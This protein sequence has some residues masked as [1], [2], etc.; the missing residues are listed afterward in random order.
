[1]ALAASRHLA[2][3]LPV[4]VVAATSLLLVDHC[5]VLLADAGAADRV[6]RADLRLVFVLGGFVLACA[7]LVGVQ[8]ARV[9]G[10]LMGPERRLVDALR[11]MR[12]GDLAFRVHVRR[13]DPL[14]GVVRECNELL[15][16]L[17]ANPPAGVRT[18][19]DV[20]EMESAVAAEDTP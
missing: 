12:S 6:V 20:I 18:G 5:R 19:G 9:A 8:A 11:R 3:V 16:W 13:G 7:A 4:L 10:R 2:L 17:N 14:T 15:D 1:M